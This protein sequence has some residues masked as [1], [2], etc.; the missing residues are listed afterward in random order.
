MKRKFL[1]LILA[2]LMVLILASCGGGKAKEKAEYIENLKLAQ[3]TMLHGGA[4]AEEVCNLTKKVWYNTIYEK[5]DD[6]TDQYTI[7]SYSGKFHSDF[8]TSLEHLY[9]DQSV[10]QDIASIQENQEEVAELIKKLQNPPDDLTSCY[11]TIDSM[12]DTYQDL[13]ALAISPS[14]SLT[15]YSQNFSDYDKDFM[16]SYEKLNAQL[17]DE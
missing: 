1:M 9:S 14:G 2:G 10:K 7:N 16:K 15:T 5:K 8:N 3:T 6:E 4:T 17:P 12:Y 13:T 11:T